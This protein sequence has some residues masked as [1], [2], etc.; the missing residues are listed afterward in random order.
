MRTWFVRGARPTASSLLL[1]VSL[2]L[3]PVPPVYAYSVLSHEAV[4]D[5]AWKDSIEPLLKARFPQATDDD[6]NHAH[7]F[8]Y[9]GSVIQDIGYYP[10]G[11]KFAS[12]LLHYVRSGDFI[13][14][15]VNES[16][17]LDEYA[18]ALGALAHYSSDTNGHPAVNEATAYEYPKLRAKYGPRVTYDEDPVAHL[19]TEFGFDVVQIGRGRYATDD[20]HKFIG[21]EV[22]KPLIERAFRD[23]YGFE[24]K[25]I[26]PSEDHAINSYRYDVSTLIPEFTR[27][28][29]V[30]YGEELKKQD[31]HFDRKKFVYRMR[32]AEF[33]KQYGK[34]Y[35]KPGRGA[36]VLA[37]LVRILP[38]VGPLKALQLKLPDAHV[39]ALYLNSLDK[40]EEH[41]HARLTELKSQPMTRE[42]KIDLPNRDLDTGA[43]TRL[44]EY[45]LADHTYDRLVI[46]IVKKGKPVP[47][48][49]RENIL[50]FYDGPPA[51]P[52]DRQP[53]TKK[54]EAHTKDEAEVR[55]A[56]EVLRAAKPTEIKTSDEPTEEQQPPAPKPDAAHPSPKPDAVPPPPPANAPN[57]PS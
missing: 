50:T 8:A 3:L 22:A 39:E 14:A 44:K 1:L 53:A 13:R 45:A 33:E 10:H 20:Y 18:F 54:T 19:R 16:S 28:A 11:E 7:A 17:D 35:E 43:P 29:L 23:I 25:E 49:L 5:M 57:N 32:R 21:F 6:L 30:Q 9:G 40:T 2:F 24:L 55:H 52:S 12:D 31:P 37:F 26:M 51:P 47:P 34:N 56:L 15:M 46:L 42:A 48:D 4:V 41:Y 36:H 27:V 38:K